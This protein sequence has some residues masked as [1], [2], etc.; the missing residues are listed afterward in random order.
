MTPHNH[1]KAGDYAEAVL[2]PGD[3]LRA[4]WIAE[5]FLDDPKL[6][7]SVR[8]CLGY[9]GTYKGKRVSVQ[10]SGMGQPSLSIYVHELINVYGLKTLI[11]VG[12]CGGLNAKVKVR[13][14]ILAQAASTDSA[15]V[16]DRF[17]AYNFAPIADFGLLRAAA[18]KAEARNMRF[19]AGNMLSSDIFYH[20]D[21]FAGYDKLP[22]HGVLGVEMEA[23]A[24][25][26]L[27]ARFGVKALTICTMTDCLITKEEIDADQRQTSLKD[28][29]T[30]ALEVAIEA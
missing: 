12:T 8:N 4:K 28:M 24:L 17:G 3:P 10:A 2:L 25:Y 15:I 23:A 27:A 7:N 26:T 20:A 5:T 16:R 11:R 19:H 18:E 1:A 30:I 9:T 22:D 29:V 13:D 21:G 14:L 6:V